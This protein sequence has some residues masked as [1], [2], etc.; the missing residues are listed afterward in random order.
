VTWKETKAIKKKRSILYQDNRNALNGPDPIL[1]RLKGVSIL[2]V[3]KDNVL[4]RECLWGTLL[5][6]VHLG[7]FP[8]VH[9]SRHFRRF[10]S[11]GPRE[12]DYSLNW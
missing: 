3:L 1:H 10:C 8:Q 11:S 9:T 7:M 6:Q 2:T 4:R 5:T 12:L